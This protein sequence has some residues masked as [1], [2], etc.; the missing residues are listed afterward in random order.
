MTSCGPLLAQSGVAL[1]STD[2]ATQSFTMA[3]VMSSSSLVFM[4]WLQL[5]WSLWSTAAN[6]RVLSSRFFRDLA[7]FFPP[8]SVR[9][10]GCFPSH[11]LPPRAVSGPLALS[12]R[13]SLWQRVLC[14]SGNRLGLAAS[15]LHPPRGPLCARANAKLRSCIAYKDPQRIWVIRPWLLC[16]ATSNSDRSCRHCVKKCPRGQRARVTSSSEM[17]NHEWQHRECIQQRV[18]GRLKEE[19]QHRFS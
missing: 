18:K 8:R 14:S 13:G 4:L 12:R 10:A 15:R 7:K 6:I 5:G 16:V 11:P 19:D 9:Y 17:W 2:F 3:T 1:S